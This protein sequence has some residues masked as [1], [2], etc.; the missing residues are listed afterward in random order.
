MKTENLFIY[1]S[2]LFSFYSVYSQHTISGYVFDDSTSEPLPGA[3]ILIRETTN[4][5]I[6]GID[7][8]FRIETRGTLPLYLEIT[9]LGYENKTVELSGWNPIEVYLTEKNAELDEVVVTSRRRVESVQK[10]PIPISVIGASK[11]Q[12]SGSFNVNRLKELIPS[13]QLYSSNPRNTGINI[14]GLGAP[15]GLTND[16]LD[17]GVGFYVDGVYYARPAAATFDFIDIERIEVLRGPQGTLFGKNTTAGAFNITTNK[18]TFIP[19]A[20]IEVT[21]GNY[22]YIQ[23]K[24][25]INGPIIKN[26]LAGRIS[27]SGTQRDGTIYNT[28]KDEYVNDINNLGFR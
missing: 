4:S 22:G 19:S 6:T 14:R 9:Y 26:L 1:I 18:P 24:S 20:D 27:F 17:P 11:I 8:S 21:Y 16:G 10:V 5:V 23:A 7:G 2:F 12:E 25:A 13:V 28:A 15:F 3:T